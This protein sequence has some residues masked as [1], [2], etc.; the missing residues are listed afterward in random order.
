[1]PTPGVPAEP[2]AHS[3][4]RRPR[5]LIVALSLDTGGTERHIAAIAPGLQAEGLDV[6]VACLRRPGVGA[7]DL[8]R[9][10]VRVIGF[11]LPERVLEGSAPLRLAGY[12]LGSARAAPAILARPEIVHAFLPLPYLVGGVLARLAGVHI[13][14]MSRRSQRDYQRKHPRLAAWEHRLHRHM[15]LVLGNSRR[16]CEELE[17]EEGVPRERLGLIY[18]GID[19]APF[20]QPLDRGAARDRLGLPREAIVLA[21]VANLIPYKGH[22]DLLN[23]LAGANLPDPWRLV[24]IGR[25]DGLG[26][27]LREQAR[28]LDLGDKLLWLGVRR[29]V[30]EILAAADIGLNCSHEEGFSNAVVE[31][32]AA[33]LAMIVTDVGGSAEAV[34]DGECGRVVP[35]G[36][37]TALRKA[38]VEL[39]SDLT[40][41]RRMGAAARA[42]AIAQFSLEACIARYAALYRALLAGDPAAPIVGLDAVGLAD[43]R[44]ER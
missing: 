25:D 11:D 18:N 31:G 38:I 36:D 24:L 13:R 8:R 19:L 21:L 29:D 26:P 9:R 43:A 15:T 41:A 30:P 28:A 27:E 37:L 32:M 39:A 40:A 34:L 23:A 10:G 22:A 42:R 5:L 7:P 17:R 4:A 3:P 35:P 44:P 2:L 20:R 1:M 14:L 12:L 33:G 16:V 6:T